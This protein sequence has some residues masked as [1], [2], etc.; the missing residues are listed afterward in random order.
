[1]QLGVS[2]ETMAQRDTKL[3]GRNL[4]KSLVSFFYFLKKKS[5]LTYKL[6]AIARLAD[7]LLGYKDARKL[8]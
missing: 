2:R 7:G 1:M 6:K 5:V 3:L 4:A 8:L